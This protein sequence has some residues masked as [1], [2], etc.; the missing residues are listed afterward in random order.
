MQILQSIHVGIVDILDRDAGGDGCAQRR[1]VS[2]VAAYRLGPDGAY[3]VEDGGE[4]RFLHSDPW[5]TGPGGWE[6]GRLLEA[7]PASL[8]PPLR[9]GKIVG[10]GRSYAE[11]AS[12]LGNEV[13]GEPL[14]F[15]KPPSSLI[16]SGAHIEI[17]SDSQRGDGEG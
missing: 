7:P 2:H 6:F 16:P 13:P 11:H 15:L 5:E 9:P 8:L 12:E 4:F 1:V 3:V 10:V 14:I 17:P